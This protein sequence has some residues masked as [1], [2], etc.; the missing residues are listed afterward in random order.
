M[1]EIGDYVAQQHPNQ[2]L[3]LKKGIVIESLKESYTVH[4]LTYNREWWMDGIDDG[5][6][7]LNERYVLSKMSYHRQN[8][9]ADIVILNKAG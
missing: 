2:K 8:D 3:F 9:H 4:W 1:I 7:G 6:K 5:F